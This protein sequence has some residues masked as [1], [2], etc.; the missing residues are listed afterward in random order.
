MKKF[1]EDEKGKIAIEALI[2]IFEMSDRAESLGGAACIS[3][4]AAL[5]SLQKSI[6]K[7]KTRFLQILS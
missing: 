1:T 2:A 5:N 7:N 6:Q 3:G 4:V